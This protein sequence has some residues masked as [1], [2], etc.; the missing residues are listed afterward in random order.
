LGI[1][2]ADILMGVKNYPRPGVKID[3]TGHTMQGGGPIPTAMVT[4]ARLGMKASLLAVV[5]DDLLGQFV[6]DEL[7]REKVDTSLIIKKKQP[8]AVASGWYE[9]DSGRRTIVLEL[10][11]NLNP[12]DL[13]LS[14]LPPARIVHLDGRYLPVCLKLA[15]W[16]KRY[17]IPVILD[18]G[19]MRNDVSRLLPLVDHLICADAYALHYTKSKTAHEAIKKL[20]TKCSG[21]VVITEGT[22]GSLGQ[23]ASD[24]WVSQKAF[25]VKAIDTTG[26]GDVYH[27]AYIY[28]LLN[29]YNLPE[30]MRLASAA[31]AIKCTKPGGRTGIPNINQLK[32]FFDKGPKTYA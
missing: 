20:I 14:A 7:K 10:S 6:I 1:A 25:K 12:Q 17:K 24:G 5:G 21:T 9:K 28:G 27:G 30:R 13:K 29:N 26:A 31:A 18:I 23:S 2:P 4:L 22:G 32:A 19:S 3:A 8:T 15:R 11:I 16:A